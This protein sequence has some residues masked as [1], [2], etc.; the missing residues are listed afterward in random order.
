MLSFVIVGLVRFCMERH[1]NGQLYFINPISTSHMDTTT[2]AGMKAARKPLVINS[3]ARYLAPTV[4][5]RS[6]MRDGG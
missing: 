6:W 3:L 4:E 5:V 1:S 2:L